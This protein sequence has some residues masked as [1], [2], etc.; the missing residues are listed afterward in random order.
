MRIIIIGGGAAGFF[1][2]C[3]AAQHHRQAEV[4]LIEKTS[5]P[6]AKVKVSGGGRCN[7]THNCLEI[8]KLANFYPRGEKFLKKAFHQF[9]V[10][11]TLQW[12]EERGVALKAEEDGRIFPVSDSSQSII[13]CLQRETQRL[14]IQVLTQTDVL[15]L[16]QKNEQ[17]QVHTPKKVWQA[18]KVVVATGGSPKL[19]GLQWLADLGHEIVTPVPSLFT[20][21]V[22]KHPINALMGVAVPTTKVRIQ[23][24]KL[25]EEGALLITHWGFSAYAVLRLSAWG[26][27]LL[28][29]MQYQ[30]TILITWVNHY[31]EEQLRSFLQQ[32]KVQFPKR[33]ISNRNPFEL[34]NRLWDF[35]LENLEIPSEKIWGELSKQDINRLTNKLLNDEYKV[36]GKTTFKEE[37]VTCGGVSL[38]D[39]DINT[40]Q[41]KK[42]PNLYFA[43]EVMDID[44][45][46][47][48][49]NFQAAWTTGFIAGKLLK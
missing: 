16:E 48:G 43:G 3:S 19:D 39:I 2:A 21:N 34:P 13:D 36:N 28:A 25:A 45:I 18:D 35:F 17:W 8:N 44:G 33:Q 49:F 12:F 38:Q 30:F 22:P 11:D 10:K 41:S 14:G 42:C 7:V 47:G 4:I 5:K 40:M 23:G 24:T 26:A 6:L 20:F 32:Q 1:A 15:K 31:N 9:S 27:R 29:D 46:T 37:F